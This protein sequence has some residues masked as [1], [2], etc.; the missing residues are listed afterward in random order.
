MQQNEALNIAIVGG[1]P[2]CKAI[3]DMMFADRLTQ[4]QSR[5][6]GVADINPEAPGYRHAERSGIFTTMDYRDLYGLERLNMILELTGLDSLA[7][8][9]RRTKP[10]HIRLIDHVA[11]RLLWDVFSVGEEMIADRLRAEEALR[12]SQEKY[13]T[14]VENSLT[15]IYID[16]AGKIVF[17]NS[18]FAEIYGYPKNQVIGMASRDLVHPEDRSMTNHIRGKRLEGN[19]A[20]TEYEARGLAKNGQTI[21]VKR[22]NIRI[23]YEGGYAILGNIVDITGHKEAETGM[24]E[25]QERYLAVLEASPDPVAVYDMQ[26]R[27]IYINPVFTK[28]FG[29][30]SEEL[31]GKRIAYVP[32]E[33]QPETQMIIRK[34]LAGQDCSGVES[35]RYTK[36]GEILDVSI[37][38]AVY[39]N[40]QGVPVGS[41]HILRDITDQKRAQAALKR[42]RLKLEKRVQ[43]RTAELSAANTQL[44]HEMEERKRAGRELK[45]SEEK[46]RVLFNYDP[47]PLFMVEM[48][49]CDIQDVNEQATL[50]YQYDRQDVRG[51]SFFQLFDADHG[52]RLRQEFGQL[53]NKGDYI[54]VP[55][56]WAERKDGTR[57]F[58]DLHARVVRFEEISSGRLS[59]SLVVRT[60]DISQQLEQQAQVIQ[61]GK[62]ATLGEMATGMAHELNQPLNVIRM[63]ADFCAKMIKR[64]KK[65][66]DQTLLQVSSNIGGQVERASAIINHLREFGRKSSFKVYPLDLNGPVGDV[67]KIMGEQLRLRNIEVSLDLGE[68]LPRVL[69]DQNRL[70]QIFLNLVTNARDAMGAGA[71]RRLGITTCRRDDMVVAEVS[72]TGHGIPEAAMQRIFEPF[73]TTKEAGRGTGLGLSITYN[74]V[75]DFKGNIDVESTLNVGTTFRLAFPAYQEKETS[76]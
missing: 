5:V 38:A 76:E 20:P 55:K 66:P 47:N 39:R 67:V 50:V 23:K 30:T 61:A 68:G 37:S 12:K 16:Q 10:A 63:G 75:K 32:E 48:D 52:E 74:L 17:A 15:G 72:D 29:W 4:L 28:V 9:I 6:I 8:E 64:G 7:D 46:Y 57:F 54:F 53:C 27:D 65:I 1:G 62:M 13:S 2:G 31:I 71:T 3:M 58:I 21:W 25:S 51:R 56:L 60:V 41:I 19:S 69:A 33:N 43:E 70:E 49:S 40:R 42:A 73:F 26:G 44:K 22:R 24:Q 11:S 59:L 35:R 36:H 14:L 45:A 34:V 18:R